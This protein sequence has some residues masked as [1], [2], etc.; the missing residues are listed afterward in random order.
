[1]YIVYYRS[2][3]LRC[4][5]FAWPNPHRL[6]NT[7]GHL[8]AEMEEDSPEVAAVVVVDMPVTADTHR[9]AE[10]AV[11]REETVWEVVEDMRRFQVVFRHL[12]A[13]MLTSS[14]WNKCDRSCCVKKPSRAAPAEVVVVVVV[15]ELPQAATDLPREAMDHLHR[16]MAFQANPVDV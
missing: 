12:K 9:V 13:R 11:S 3:P 4:S 7:I 8:V 10:A 16:P 1:M 5:L 14:C 15:V 2:L 6:I